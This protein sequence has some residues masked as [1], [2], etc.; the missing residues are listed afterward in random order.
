MSLPDAQ[1][2]NRHLLFPQFLC[3]RPGPGIAFTCKCRWDLSPFLFLLISSL[4]SSQSSGPWSIAYRVT[5]LEALFGHVILLPHPVETAQ[6]QGYT[7][8]CHQFCRLYILL[9]RPCPSS[10]SASPASIHTSSS[11]ISSF[12]LGKPSE[13]PLSDSGGMSHP[14]SQLCFK[15]QG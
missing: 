12:S 1:E 7:K 9:P 10:Q 6:N 5:F 8:T 3:L 2:I 13:S 14:H 15:K 4:P 11:S